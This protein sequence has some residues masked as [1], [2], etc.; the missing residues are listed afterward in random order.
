LNAGVLLHAFSPATMNPQLK[1]R[2]QMECCRTSNLAREKSKSP[3]RRYRGF[4]DSRM[5]GDPTS[6]GAPQRGR[7]APHL[8][9]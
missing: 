4:A 5:G 7:V 9:P 8:P 3:H 1:S 2:P 6:A